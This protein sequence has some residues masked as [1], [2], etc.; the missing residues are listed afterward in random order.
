[1]AQYSVIQE[2]KDRLDAVSVIGRYVQLKKSGNSYRGLCPFHSEKTPSFHV[3]P[4]TNTWKCFGCGAG[5]DIFTFVEKRENLPFPDVLRML[6]KEAG[7]PL[8][9]TRPEIRNAR[10]RLLDIHSAATSFFQKN[11]LLGPEG[12]RARE[13]LARRG[14]SQESIEQFQLGFAQDGWEYLI[15]HLQSQGFS[16]DEI[17]KAGL[18]I[19]RESG[20][21]RKPRLSISTSQARSNARPT[22]SR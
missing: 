12:M 7:V 1:M 14:I 11:L 20:G 8:Q 3:F 2:I 4:Q 16:L 9:E 19:P 13:Y 22:N 10:Q 5:G 17:V 15:N 21:G 6:A 18:A